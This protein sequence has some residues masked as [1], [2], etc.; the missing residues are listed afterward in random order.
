[1]RPR[2]EIRAA[3]VAAAPPA[4]PP[5][6]LGGATWRDLAQQACVSYG[7]ARRTADNMVAAGE[8]IVVGHRREAHACRP[9][10]VFA[11]PADAAAPAPVT[12]AL[13]ELATCWAAFR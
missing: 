6:V 8:L 1:M 7:L 12:Q 3:M 13:D 2:G 4:P 9:M 10:R 11:R 5:G